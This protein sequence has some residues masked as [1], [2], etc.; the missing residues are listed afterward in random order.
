MNQSRTGIDGP[1]VLRGATFGKRSRLRAVEGVQEASAT[2]H[3]ALVI[4]LEDIFD[5]LKGF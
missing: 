1:A 4:E 3:A 5:D 2:C